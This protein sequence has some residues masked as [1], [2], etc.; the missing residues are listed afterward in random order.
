MIDQQ[1]LVYLLWHF[2]DLRIN[3]VLSRRGCGYRDGEEKARQDI[4]P[5]KTFEKMA[6]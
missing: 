2:H 3:K 6:V 5:Y 4:S 1:G